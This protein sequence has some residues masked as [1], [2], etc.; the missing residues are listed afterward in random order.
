MVSTT[1]ICCVSTA[2]H[3]TTIDNLHRGAGDDLMRAVANK[4]LE[5]LYGP[6]IRAL[7]R[8]ANDAPKAVGMAGLAALWS[9]HPHIDV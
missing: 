4:S 7:A 9:G 3:P 2:F 5:R 6:S 8:R 1:T